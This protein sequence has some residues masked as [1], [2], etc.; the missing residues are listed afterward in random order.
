MTKKMKL[1]CSDHW[2]KNIFPWWLTTSH[3]C[4]LK[5][6]W[7]YCHNGSNNSK[8]THNCITWNQFWKIS[9]CWQWTSQWKFCVNHNDSWQH[10]NKHQI[11]NHCLWIDQEQEILW[12]MWSSSLWIV[13]RFLIHWINFPLMCHQ[14]NALS[15]VFWKSA[16]HDWRTSV[17]QNSESDLSWTNAKP[18]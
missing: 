3:F 16:Q 13:G 17:A 2:L 6:T 9:S 11:N 14:K 12:L 7:N 10:H 15:P 8:K 5:N 18:M 4:E 1:N